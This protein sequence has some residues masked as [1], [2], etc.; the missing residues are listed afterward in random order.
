MKRPVQT[1]WHARARDIL[2]REMEA[3]G[4]SYRELAER[5]GSSR[6]ALTNKIAR[7]VFVTSWFLEALAAMG[8]KSIRLDQ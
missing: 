3:R 1:D 6:A 8:V 2:Q 5:L 4:V 7:G